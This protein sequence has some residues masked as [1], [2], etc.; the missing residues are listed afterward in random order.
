ME[1]AAQ[2]PDAF[3]ERLYEQLGTDDAERALRGFETPR[4]R[5]V[6]ANRLR[7]TPREL[8][9]ELEAEGLEPEPAPAPYEDALLLAPDAL[10]AVQGTAAAREGRLYLQGLAS[11]AAVIA[12]DPQPGED[13]LDLCAAPGSKTSQIAACMRG[14]GRLVAND[15]SRK[16]GF[17]LRAVLESQGALDLVRL[18][19]ARG[20]ALARREPGA[21]DRV[22][23]DAPCSG[24]GRFRSDDPRTFAEWSP[25]K[26]K[27]LAAEQRRLLLA[28]AV[29]LRPGGTLV[30]STC[31]FAP[32]E[33]EQALHKVLRRLDGALALEALPVRFPG[34]RAALTEWRGRR[35]D[36]S[37]AHARR[38]LPDERQEGFFVARLVKR[39]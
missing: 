2:W 21:F 4:A 20:E 15:R 25:A 13:V 28:A 32:A 19:T 22:L 8:R 3:V 5:A 27:R 38:L 30:Y 24:E 26:V 33:N 23:V 6:R 11:Q 34:E 39:R 35:L 31:T 10:R 16:R 7:T 36:P 1:R 9:A 14:A 29:A 37:L 18:V 12:L 17:K